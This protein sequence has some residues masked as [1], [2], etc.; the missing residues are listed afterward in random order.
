CEDC[1]A[2]RVG[3]SEPDIEMTDEVIIFIIGLN[4]PH[5]AERGNPSHLSGIEEALERDCACAS[6]ARDGRARLR[7]TT[8]AATG[9]RKRGSGSLPPWRRTWHD[10]PWLRAIRYSP[11]GGCSERFASSAS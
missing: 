8:L 10:P 3:V 4:G 7:K 1:N 5:R 11:A 9:R 6:A 2:S